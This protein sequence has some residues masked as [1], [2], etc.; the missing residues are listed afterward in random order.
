MKLIL[1]VKT[2][3]DVTTLEL[4]RKAAPKFDVELLEFDFERPIP[5]LDPTEKYLLYRVTPRRGSFQVEKFIYDRYLCVTVL[6]CP[7]NPA[8]NTAH[9]LAGIP[10]PLSEVASDADE[11]TLREKVER[12][13][14]FPVVVKDK[15]PGG[16]GIGVMRAD[17]MESLRSIA[18]LILAQSR[19]KAFLVQQF[20][21]HTQH[22]RLVVLGDE[23]IDSIAYNAYA[24][25]F[26]TNSTHDVVDVEPWKF[27]DAVEQ[28][29]IRA[30]HANLVDFGGVDIIVDGE[31]LYVL[32]VN[33]PSY[34]PRAE[35]CTHF[36]TSE[37]L[38]QYLAAKA[39]YRPQNRWPAERAR[40]TLLLISEPGDN[41]TKREFHKNARHLGI[42]VLEVD[43]N[44]PPPSLPAD[45]IYLLYRS[46]LDGRGREIELHRKYD[47]TSFAADY[48]VLGRADYNRNRHYREAGLPFVAKTAVERKDIDHLKSRVEELGDPPLLL[49]SWDSRGADLAR[50]DTFQ[51]FVSLV[52]YIFALGRNLAVQPF[53]E[54]EHYARLVVL[55]DEVVSSIEYLSA[56][57]TAY[58]FDDFD[59]AI[60]R[61]YPEEVERLA[62]AAAQSHR[63]HCAA[64]KIIIDR[65]GACFVE[66]TLFPF[67]F[68]RDEHVT[69]INVTERMLDFLLARSAEKQGF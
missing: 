42:P 13:Q 20:V 33:T 64:V 66:D 48:P 59:M 68:Y 35:L 7:Y 28:L 6:R 46:S 69:G 16:H 24:F 30:A 36:P 41:P 31:N 18:R 51:S 67:Y 25:D 19:N 62:V 43:P 34:F 27:P 49:K 61:R 22:A 21:P 57:P 17:S 32:E 60:P 23:V 45:G 44:A 15:V 53:I 11:G 2:G 3:D 9:R 52:D 29:A 37:R 63:L 8:Q 14:G 12:V 56:D 54:V 50:A 47:C 58:A 38:V 40:P 1:I 5:D 65:D 26:R 4:L 39:A 55:G 10:V